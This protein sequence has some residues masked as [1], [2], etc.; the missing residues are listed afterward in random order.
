MMLGRIRRWFSPQRVDL[1]HVDPRFLRKTHKNVDWSG[2]DLNHFVPVG[3]RFESCNFSNANLLG[4]C[5]GGG[6]EDCVYIDCT[7]DRATIRATA[8]GNAHFGSCKFRNV[9][10]EE[11][12]AFCVEMVD[13][14]ISG[15]VRAAFFNGT[16]PEDRVQALKRKRNRFERNDFSRARLVDVAFRTGIDL[17][18]QKLPA[19]WKNEA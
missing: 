13:C 5:F 19:G 8:A 7:F 1:S 9:D 16:V 17:S 14:E 2:Q 3:C 4:T 12:F 10:I 18:L 11:F 15:I 6:L